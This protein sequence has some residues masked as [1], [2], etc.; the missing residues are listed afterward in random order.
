LEAVKFVV[1]GFV[2]SF[3]IPQTSVYQL[4]YLAPTKTQ[5]VGMLTNVMGKSE[6]DY[7]RLLKEAK[8]GIV[9]L[10]IETV[11]VD[12]WLY[13]KWKAANL[14]R[15]ILKRE[16]L[17]NPRYLLYI[18]ASNAE[19]IK[20]ALEMPKRIPSLG[21]DDELIEIKEVAKS[22]LKGPSG[23]KIVHSIFRWDGETRFKPKLLGHQQPMTKETQIYMP[24]V[25]TVNFD[26]D[27]DVVPRKP[28]NHVQIVEFSGICVE[29]DREMGLYFDGERWVDMF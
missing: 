11:F 15:A 16:K 13:K 17:L 26:F 3:R 27:F 24:R 2:N 19:E 6:R 21:Q 28:Q 7:H 9:P 29:L 10:S 14:G 23:S 8:V 22:P 1:K 4:T 18:S 25:V 12:V 20:E 5:I